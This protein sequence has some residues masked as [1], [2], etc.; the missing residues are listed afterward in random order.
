VSRKQSSACS[1]RCSRLP[2]YCAIATAPE[3]TAPLT[4]SR[5]AS[6][7][8]H[9]HAARTNVRSTSLKRLGSLTTTSLNALGTDSVH[10]R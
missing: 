8:C 10:C 6:P 4:P 2:K 9:L 1:A 3:L 7:R 5:R